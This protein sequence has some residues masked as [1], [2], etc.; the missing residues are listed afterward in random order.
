MTMWL[1]RQEAM[2]WFSSYLQWAVPG[3]VIEGLDADAE[4]DNENDEGGKDEEDKEGDEGEKK[5]YQITLRPPFPNLQISAVSKK[6]NAPNFLWYLN[7]FME[8]QCIVP[9]TTLTSTHGLLYTK[10]L[11]LS[12]LRSEKQNRIRE[13]MLFK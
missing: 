7:G 12:F 9:S 2:Q 1:S 11:V 5:P 3:Y 8:L 13:R 4:E 6:Y 10:T